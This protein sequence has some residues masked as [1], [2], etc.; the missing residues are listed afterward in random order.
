MDRLNR[1]RERVS[2]E[3]ARGK[4]RREMKYCDRCFCNCSRR[5]RIVFRKPSKE[6]VKYVVVEKSL[7]WRR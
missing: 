3:N 2:G 4:T 1:G 5:V 7:Y 6:I